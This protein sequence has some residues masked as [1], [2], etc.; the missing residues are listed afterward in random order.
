[1]GGRVVFLVVAVL[2]VAYLG[3]FVRVAVEYVLEYYC[4]KVVVVVVFFEREL[5][6]LQLPSTYG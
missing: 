5:K 2:F 1:M 6:P 4:P 3:L